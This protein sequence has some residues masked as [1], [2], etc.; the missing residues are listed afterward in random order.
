LQDLTPVFY[1]DLRSPD[2]WL[3]AERMTH[4]LG[5]VPEWQPVLLDGLGG[6][7]PWWSGDGRERGMAD[8]ELRASGQGI[9]PLRWPDGWPNDVTTAML[10]AA[11]AKQA[12][13]A[14]AYSLA[15]FRQQFAAG[16]DL[17]VTDN[18]LIAAAACELHPRALLKGVESRAVR[19]E[20]DGATHE[21]A[22]RGVR[23][24]PAIRAGDEIY[25]GPDAPEL[26]AR[27]V[28]PRRHD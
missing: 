1:Y 5:L 9:R 21:A 22:D 18:V 12:A 17:S 14:V 23:E 13:R 11:F 28:R 20:L 6:P 3:A 16:R 24:L 7:V 2:C 25:A 4:T 10:A 15:A 8:V 27:G 19:D 26:A